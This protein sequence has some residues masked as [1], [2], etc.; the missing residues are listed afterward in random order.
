MVGAI[1]NIS[2]DHT[3]SG[4]ERIPVKSLGQEDFIKILVTQLTSQD[5]M[6][7][8]KD[9]EFIGQMAQFS[10]LESS[11][12]MQT[13]L[14]SMRAQQEFVKA[15]SV[16]GRNVELVDEED[17]NITGVVSAVEMLSGKPHVIV[18]E[19]PYPMEGVIRVWQNG[20]AVSVPTTINQPTPVP[21]PRE[22]K[23]AE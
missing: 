1:S 21:A 10:A 4:A 11:K 19:K 23:Q 8:Q 15:N 3:P 6:N 18:N 9:T 14:Q 22:H 20:A 12:L 13:E 16:I 7:P 5:P 17:N 2:T